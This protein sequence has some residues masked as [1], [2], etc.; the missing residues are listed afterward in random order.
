MNILI[1]ESNDAIPKLGKLLI[2]ITGTYYHSPPS[3]LKTSVR[4]FKYL[5]EYDHPDWSKTYLL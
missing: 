1:Q 3:L 4:I 2:H 5:R